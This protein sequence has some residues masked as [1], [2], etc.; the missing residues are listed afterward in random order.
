[1]LHDENVIAYP[2]ESMFGLG[3][4]PTSEEAVKKLLFLK[5]RTI[6]KGFI[7]VASDFDQVRMY[8]NENDLS[9]K[10]KNKIFCYW[11][12]PFTF[13]LPAKYNVP[14]WLTG[15]F[16]TIAVR[17]SAHIGI[18]QLCNAFG[19]AVIS[20]SANISNM[21]PCITSEEVF[22]CFGKDFP[23]LSG[24]IGNERHPSRIIN[25]INGNIIRHV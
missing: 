10:Q 25:I 13:L 5:K 20:T 8:I 11:P 12:G 22:K 6:E 3:C 14:Y 7:L 24:K 15:K 16:N 17:I 23:L 19:K 2:T 9:K 4:D 21:N 18:I 1:M